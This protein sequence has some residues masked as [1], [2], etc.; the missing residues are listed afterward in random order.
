MHGRSWISEIDCDHMMNLDK[1]SSQTEGPRRLFKLSSIISLGAL[2]LSTIFLMPITSIAS[3]SGQASSAQQW[4]FNP[5]TGYEGEAS[6]TN[7]N[8]SRFDVSCGNG[9]APGFMLHHPSSPLLTSGANE[10]RVPLK[11]EIDGKD[12]EQVF[13][14]YRGELVCVSF[15]F[16][17][18]ALMTAMQDGD[19]MGIEYNEQPVAKFTLANSKATISKLTA[20]LGP[21]RADWKG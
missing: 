18:V 19:R 11:M 16:P 4:Q 8:A 13:S 10:Q 6:I 14:C 5:N 1:K 12:F 7:D 15:G 3:D 9:G 20:C 21:N 17:S 2:F